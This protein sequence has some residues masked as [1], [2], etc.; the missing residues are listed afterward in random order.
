M[1]HAKRMRAVGLTA[2]LLLAA[3]AGMAARAGDAVADNLRAADI[4]KKSQAQYT[5]LTNYS[6]EGKAV[7][8]LGETSV[9]PCNYTI[10]MARPH[11]YRIAW[12]QDSG[13]F[14]QKGAVWS[15][16]AGDFLKMGT[17]VQKEP[18][19]SLALSSAAGISG[20]AAAS[21]PGAFFNVVWGNPLG[22]PPLTEKRL[23][24]AKVDSVDCFVLARDLQ[25]TTTTLWIG[26][27]DFLIHQVQRV[28]SAQA[29]KAR[30]A[31]AAKQDPKLAASLPATAAQAITSTEIHTHIVVNQKLSPADFDH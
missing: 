25:G 11:L 13:F 18:N 30:L 24:D 2:A 31:E 4:L 6:D 10:K 22:V 26:K 9:A 14:D 15:V 28:T 20:G 19:M 3:S 23:P 17:S 7:S 21:I 27:A 29:V 8:V 5:A 16:G 12:D 1:K